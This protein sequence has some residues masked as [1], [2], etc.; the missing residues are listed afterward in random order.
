M[1]RKHVVSL[2]ETF[3][4]RGDGGIESWAR[5]VTTAAHQL[6][7]EGAPVGLMFHRPEGPIFADIRGISSEDEARFLA[8]SAQVPSLVT[9]SPALFQ[10]I[11]GGIGRMVDLWSELGLEFEVTRAYRRLMGAKDLLGIRGMPEPGL[12][13]VICAS[14][15]EPRPIPTRERA[16]LTRVAVHMEAAARARLHPETVIGTLDRKGRLEF[17]RHAPDKATRDALVEHGDAIDGVRRRHARSDGEQ[18]LE[19]WRALVGGALSLVERLD[20][21]GKRFY[22]IHVNHPSRAPLR[23]LNERETLVVDYAA[24]GLQNKEIGYALG[25]PPA[26]ISKALTSGAEKLGLTSSRSLLRVA[27]LLRS[28][29]ATFDG[30]SLTDAERAVL[31][32]LAEGRTNEEIAHTRGVAV[33]TVANQVASVLAK[34][35]QKSRRAFHTTR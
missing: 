32:L 29:V 5:E 31:A 19:V 13:L 18:A 27:A 15:P 1:D 17:D 28:P 6:L 11:M 7:Q 30:S 26:T 35:G 9:E 14:L 3:Y 16:L 10:R 20:T 22:D 2:L 8:L 12:G 24:R 21:D 23:S 4:R 34:T 33:R 25:L